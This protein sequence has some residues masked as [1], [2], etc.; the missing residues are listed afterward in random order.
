M[1]QLWSYKGIF[2]KPDPRTEIGTALEAEA[3]IGQLSPG[4][5]GT[6]T[7]LEA[8]LPEVG[9]RQGMVSPKI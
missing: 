2:G 6:L 3:A 5:N 1:L 4:G 7:C 9:V 8:R